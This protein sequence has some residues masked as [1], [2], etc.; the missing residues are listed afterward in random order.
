MCLLNNKLIIKD[1]KSKFGTLALIRDFYEVTDKT[2]CLQIGRS[3]TECNL[4][5]HKDYTK[6]KN[7]VTTTI[8][9]KSKNKQLFR[10]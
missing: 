5:G 1:L 6:L 7:E 3:Y 10:K 4:I 2:V 8:H 9:D